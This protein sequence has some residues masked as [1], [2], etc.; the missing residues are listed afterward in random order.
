MFK[1]FNP[2]KNERDALIFAAIFP[3][4]I[5]MIELGLNMFATHYLRLHDPDCY[6]RLVRLEQFLTTGDWFSSIIPESNAPFGENLHWTRLYDIFLILLILPVWLLTF[7]LHKAIFIVGFCVGPLL[8]MG[9]GVMTYKLFN[10]LYSKTVAL[11]SVVVISLMPA[12]SELGAFGATD[13]HIFFAFMHLGWL[14]SFIYAA[15]KEDDRFF[16]LSGIF[17]IM[18]LW[19]STSGLL[20][21][22][23]TLL[24]LSLYWIATGKKLDSMLAFFK[25][26]GI[27]V[28]V[29]YLIERHY[30]EWA[31]IEYDKLS[32]PY[33]A[34]PLLFWGLFTLLAR[35]EQ[36]FPAQTMGHRFMR[37][38]FLGFVFASIYLVSFPG[39]FR[40]PLADAPPYLKERF[41]SVVVEAKPLSQVISN[42]PWYYL[43]FH[44]MPIFLMIGLSSY[45]LYKRRSLAFLLHLIA[46]LFLIPPS[47]Y[48]VRF[49]SLIHP[50]FLLPFMF[51]IKDM[52]GKRIKKI[53]VLPFILFLPVLSSFLPME[54][55]RYYDQRVKKIVNSMN[56]SPV[57][58]DALVLFSKRLPP[59]EK[60]RKPILLTYLFMGPEIIWLTDFRTIGSPY[61]RNIEGMVSS[62]II[63][64]SR[65]EQDM[66]NEIHRR[67][68]DYIMVSPVEVRDSW[69]MVAGHEMSLHQRMIN[70][71][72][73]PPFLELMPFPEYAWRVMIYKVDKEKLKEYL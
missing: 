16:I 60:A 62:D 7:S 13:H 12:F 6:M 41:L 35:G 27:S 52:E 10:A 25:G 69:N 24:T 26:A 30:T 5:A 54:I 31:I 11:T 32:L 47:I 46:V 64:S 18:A 39:F 56:I 21:I 23:L 65:I 59:E 48:Q 68:I 29:A 45:Y 51:L 9:C 36:R 3:L 67:E 28:L 17:S 38:A 66:I 34:L 37:M 55:P 4:C 73:V 71:H 53:P 61:H 50:F 19:I 20:L 2:L 1:N 58:T 42:A 8:F 40:G 22:A 49:I 43:T 14:Y 63:L 72:H 70:K 15:K 33:L 57:T 44:F